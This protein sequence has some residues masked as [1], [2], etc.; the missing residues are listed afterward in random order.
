MAVRIKNTTSAMKT[1]KPV[2]I[3]RTGKIVYKVEPKKAKPKPLPTVIDMVFEASTCLMSGIYYRLSEELVLIFR[4]SGRA[5]T[6][7]GVP[8]SVV[9]GLKRAASKGRYFNYN[10]RDIY[11]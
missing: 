4:T 8:L 9:N 11:E 7:Y 1:R 5:Y 10:I 6:Y 2:K 3:G